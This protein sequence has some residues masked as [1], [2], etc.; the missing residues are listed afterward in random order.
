MEAIVREIR[1]LIEREPE[2]DPAS[3]HV[4]FRDYS[5]SSL[6]IWTAYV[7]RD[8]DFT[9]HMA[10]RQRLNLAIMRA[11]DAQGLAFAY[12]T[13]TMHLPEPIVGKITGQQG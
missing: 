8:P 11:V 3:V 5:E 7:V 4:Y 9:R 13:Q 1:Q 6:D 10:L 12:P 2:V